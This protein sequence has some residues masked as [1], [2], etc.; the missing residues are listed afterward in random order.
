MWERERKIF[1]RDSSIKYIICTTLAST[2]LFLCGKESQS[3]STLV[4]FIVE[5][6]VN[7]VRDE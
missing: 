6:R 1:I 2:G 7:Q 3:S 5:K 4:F